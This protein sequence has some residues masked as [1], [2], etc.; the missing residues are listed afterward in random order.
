MNLKFIGTDGSMGLRHGE[1]YDVLV[2][3]MFRENYI[4]VKWLDGFETRQCPYS[5]PAAFAANWAKPGQKVVVREKGA[6][7]DVRQCKAD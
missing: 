1:V 6:E 3:C 2:S 4:F 5:S 7:T